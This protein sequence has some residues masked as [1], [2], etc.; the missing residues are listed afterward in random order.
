MTLT[1]VVPAGHWSAHL[2]DILRCAKAGDAVIV[3]NESTRLL[4]ERA[5]A[6]MYPEKKIII[7]V[8]EANNVTTSDR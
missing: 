7:K 6:R 5:L 2:A 3:A 8:A 1:Y 4:A